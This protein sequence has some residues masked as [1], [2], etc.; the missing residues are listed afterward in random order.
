VK[1]IWTSEKDQ[2]LVGLFASLFLGRRPL[3][4]IANDI[5][6]WFVERKIAKGKKTR[7][8]HPATFEA[9]YNE[10]A[11]GGVTP[12]AVGQSGWVATLMGFSI[13]IGLALAGFGYYVLTAIAQ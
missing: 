12:S 3:K 4:K 11:A 13:V 10:V 1:A 7:W 5:Q 9:R 2:K 6:L 8:W